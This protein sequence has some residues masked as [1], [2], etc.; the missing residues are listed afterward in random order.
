[1]MTRVKQ[2]RSYMGMTQSD[3][4]NVLDI[5]LQSYWKKEKGITPFTDDEK[6]ILKKIFNKSFPSAI[7]DDIFFNQKVSKV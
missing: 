2:M 5:S 1:M 4:A 7:I 6:V 3:L